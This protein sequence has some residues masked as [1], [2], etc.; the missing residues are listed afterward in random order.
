VSATRK[1]IGFFKVEV[2]KPED[3]AEHLEL[4]ATN[5]QQFASDQSPDI[6]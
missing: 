1:H 3:H 4:S 6:F 2:I 5:Q